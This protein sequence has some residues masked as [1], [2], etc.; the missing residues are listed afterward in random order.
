M[1]S[2]FAVLANLYGPGDDTDPQRAHVVAALIM[3]TLGAPEELL[4][5]GTGRA[6]REH[7]YVADAAQGLLALADLEA[8]G[9]LNI[10]TGQEVSVADLTQSIVEACGYDGAVRFDTTKPDGQPRKVLDVSR[11]TQELGWQAP[12][13]LSIGLAKT[14]AWYREVLG[15]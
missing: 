10:G 12:T 7:L 15:C 3:R 9:P 8:G 4:V 14:V 1:R 13:S 5:W 11:A 2:A 6:T